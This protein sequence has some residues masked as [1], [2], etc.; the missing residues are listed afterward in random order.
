MKRETILI[1]L[2]GS[3]EKDKYAREKICQDI[4]RLKS[5]GYSIVVVHGGG[6]EINE[7]LGRFEIESRFVN[8]LRVT[9]KD[10]IDI[11]CSVL[12]GKVNKEITSILCSFNVKAL[13]LSGLDC[14]LIEASYLKIADEFG[15]NIDIGYVGDVNSINTKLINA[16][17]ELDI[18]PVI[19]PIGKSKDG[20]F[21]NINADYAAAYLAGAIGAERIIFITDVDGLYENYG[22]LNQKLIQNINIS[23]LEQRI[24]QKKVSDG[25]IPKLKCCIKAASMG[26]SKVSIINGTKPQILMD[27]VA[28]N[29]IIGT[30]IVV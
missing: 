26:V 16:L 9:D 6:K 18:I 3:V 29:K 20:N 28:Y 15:N 1:K 10:T 30:S 22:E 17:H 27:A 25:M 21:L 2:G 12:C 7:W 19:A 4:A 24:A 13:G 11:V 8:G 14:D 23:E 5:F